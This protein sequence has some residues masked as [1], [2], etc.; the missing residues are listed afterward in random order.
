MPRFRITPE[1]FSVS[2]QGVEFKAAEDGTFVLPA[3]TDIQNALAA[4]G[5]TLTLIGD[6]AED[7]IAFVSEAAVIAE[8][9][10]QIAALRA[11][12]A[13]AEARAA[14]PPEARIEAEPA[15][16]KRGKAAVETPEG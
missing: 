10:A 4:H 7:D 2:V 16:K 12:L 6:A 11:Q 13:E 1:C 15:T 5:M 14:T 8:R 9:D 3:N